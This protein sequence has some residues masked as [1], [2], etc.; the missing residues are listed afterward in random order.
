MLVQLLKDRIQTRSAPIVCTACVG[1]LQLVDQPT[2]SDSIKARLDS[3]GHESKCVSLG[4]TLPVSLLH[5][6]RLLRIYV[7]DKLKIS[8]G[9]R[10]PKDLFRSMATHQL[11]DK[12]GLKV[13]ASGALK[14]TI[15]LQH[16]P[17][18]TEHHFLTQ[19]KNPV[20]K[21]RKKQKRVSDVSVR[22][23]KI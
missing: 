1:A 10:D 4:C 20:L 2:F 14:M 22:R 11:E 23:N 18:S 12:I 5:R 21:L 8:C 19:A 13:D 17:T 3:E 6:D 15:V 16:E 9:A 7:K